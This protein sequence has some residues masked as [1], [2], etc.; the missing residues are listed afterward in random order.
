VQHDISPNP[1]SEP[2]W[3]VYYADGK[4]LVNTKMKLE[5]KHRSSIWWLL[6]R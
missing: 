1:P 2:V 5:E 3:V 4:F 6:T